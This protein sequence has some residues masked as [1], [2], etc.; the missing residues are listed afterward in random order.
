MFEVFMNLFLLSPVFPSCYSGLYFFYAFS[1]LFYFVPLI[2]LE[3]LHVKFLW[4][5]G[6]RCVPPGRILI[7]F[8]LVPRDSTS[9]A[10][11]Y[12]TEFT[13]C[14]LFVWLV[15]LFQPLRQYCFQLCWHFSGELP[16]LALPKH[17]PCSSLR[18][19]EIFILVYIFPDSLK[20]KGF[21]LNPLSWVSFWPVT[22]HLATWCLGSGNS[23]S[24]GTLRANVTLVFL[25]PV[26]FL[27]SLRFCPGRSLLFYQFFDVFNIFFSIFCPVFIVV[28]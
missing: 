15:C 14:V 1:F 13:A 24:A 2:L 27:I 5:L 11:L 18:V 23:R 26:L 7:C 12:T 22:L 8:L 20:G 16:P 19:G 10:L 21:L 17:L 6:W 3:K 4:D 9:I 28:Y 25:L